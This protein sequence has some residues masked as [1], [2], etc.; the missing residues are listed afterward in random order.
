MPHPFSRTELLLGKAAMARLATARV[1]VF[2]L[3]GVG[4]CA[5]EALARSGVG[6][7]DVVDDDVVCLTNLNRQLIATRST[8]GHPKTDVMRERLLDINPTL[9]VTARPCF[10][11]RDTADTFDFAA[12]AYVVDAIDTVSAKLLLVEMA[13]AAGTPIISC[14]GAGNKLDPTR[15]QV[16]DIAK[17]S[18]CPLARVMRQELKKRGI[19]HLKVVY[20]QEPPITPLTEDGENSCKNSCVC[21]P[22][23]KRTCA[24]RR[25]V[26]GSVAFVPPVAGLILAAEV[27]KDIAAG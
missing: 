27:V 12:Y 24:I 2:G 16:A 25:Q 21:P 7:L 8:V 20:S 19:R 3:G 22:G 9:R 11:N 13:R 5:A 1:A 14:M 6:A 15:L 26:P 10:F 23:T 17:T 4:A 18:V